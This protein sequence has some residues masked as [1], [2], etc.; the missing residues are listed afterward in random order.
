MAIRIN[1]LNKH[2]IFKRFLYYYYVFTIEI[3][4]LVRRSI[5]YIW[6]AMVLAGKPKVLQLPITNLCNL[7]CIMCGIGIMKPRKQMS[8][9]ELSFILGNKLFDHVEDVGVNG[10]EPFLLKNINEYFAVLLKMLPRL[11]RIY[12]I[13][14]G[15]LNDVIT[16]RLKEIYPQCVEKGV[17]LTV[18]V[19]IDGFG[20]QHDLIRGKEGVFL[21]AEKTCITINNNRNMYCDDF[22][23]I[24]TIT[25]KNIVKINEVVVWASKHNIKISYNIA[26]LHK[27]LENENRYNDF[28]LFTDERSRMLATEFFYGKMMEQNSRRYFAIYFFLRKQKRI[29]NCSFK[30]N[31]VTLDPYGNLYYCATRSK[32]IGNAL[33]QD[34]QEIFNSAKKYRKKLIKTQCRTCSHYSEELLF[35]GGLNYLRDRLTN[36]INPAEFI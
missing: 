21:R 25:K 7:N 32:C 3:L 29:S 16:D 8:L 10:G 27:R 4:G 26:T 19:S 35:F 1:I 5:F 13:T 28:S 33:S 9:E 6:Q 18:S 11:K 14:N 24:C 31:G 34:A 15:Y 22:G 2:P 20:K 30:N 17:R 23:V 36:I 12:I